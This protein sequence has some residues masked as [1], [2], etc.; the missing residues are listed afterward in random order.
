LDLEGKR[1]SYFY[2]IYASAFETSMM[3]SKWRSQNSRPPPT[4]RERER[5]R[6]YVWG[7]ESEQGI[8]KVIL[9]SLFLLFGVWREVKD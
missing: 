8:G 7:K 1:N 6:S 2:F 9:F 3:D 5:E 4:L